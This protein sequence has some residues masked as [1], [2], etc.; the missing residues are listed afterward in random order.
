MAPGDSARLYHRLTA[1]SPETLEPLVLDLPTFPA[2]CKVY[3]GGLPEVPLPAEWPPP[4]RL[5]VA[6]LARILHLS[7]GVVRTSRRPDGRVYHFRA[8]GSAGGRSPCEVYVCARDV[9]GLDD[10]V[11]WYDPV[12]HA[13]RR[14]GPPADG[15]TTLVVTG[16][17]WRTGWQYK[18]RG[19]R[20]IYWDAGSMLAQT[21]AL[22]GPSARLFTRFP[23]AAVSRLVGADGVHEW[24]VA[25]VALAHGAPAVAPGG[26]AV[27]GEVDARPPHEFPLVTRTQRAGDGDVLGEP[28]P[29]D[30]PAIVGL[31]DVILRRGSTRRMAPVPVSRAVLEACMGAGLPGRHFVSVHAV[32]GVAP[33]LYEWP[34]LVRAGDLREELF[35]VCMEQ[36]LGRDAAFVVMAVADLE[37]LDDRGYREAQLAAG[38]GDGRIHLAAFASGAGATGMT[39]YD[40]E[41]EA[42]LGEPAAGLLF[43]CVGVPAYRSKRGGRPRAPVT[44]GTMRPR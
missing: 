8:A 18:E 29:D 36:D 1:V 6:A 42:L 30:P 17:P 15:V 24:P 3:P 2:P 9:A 4:G 25:L 12:G 35:H 39:F 44:I 11:H 16:I 43:T 21:L 10:G 32:E 28:W 26:D 38:I 41:L 40:S 14:I 7:A 20:H 5:D 19:F 34:R 23:D 33:G 13:L 37:A 31:E 22:A 27:A